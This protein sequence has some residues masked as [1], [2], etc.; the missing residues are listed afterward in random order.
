MFPVVQK[1]TRF[2]FSFPL[3]LAFVGGDS[4]DKARPA[5]FCS[6]TTAPSCTCLLMLRRLLIILLLPLPLLLLL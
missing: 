1:T 2:P 5:D 4:L 3:K 6:T